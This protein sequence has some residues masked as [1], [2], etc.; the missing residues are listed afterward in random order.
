ML[1]TGELF[2]T[3]QTSASQRS[4]PGDILRMSFNDAKISK[5]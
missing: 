3:I 2:R 5:F 4:K 1:L